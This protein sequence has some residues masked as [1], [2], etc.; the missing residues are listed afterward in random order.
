MIRV[1]EVIPDIKTMHKTGVHTKWIGTHELFKNKKILI[2]GVPG[3]FLVEYA[4]THMRTYEFCYEIIQKLGIDEIWVTSVDDC[5]V[6]NAWLKHEGI[7]KVKSLPD[8]AGEWADT[9]GLLEDMTREGL[10][11]YRSHRYA[12]IIDNLICK[13]VKY[14]DFTHNPMTC[15]QVSDADSMIKYLESIKTTYERWNDD[16]RDKVNANGQRR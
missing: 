11:K 14:E 2:F 4:A 5:Y 16:A 1:A 8:P 10:G 7:K 3:L 13:T 12:M 9:I 15:F 6:Q